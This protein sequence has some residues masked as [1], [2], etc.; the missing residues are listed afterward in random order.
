MG[1]ARE[2][3]VGRHA[4]MPSGRGTWARASGFTLI[5]V[6]IAIAV[7][8]ILTAIALPQYNEFVRRSRIVDATSQLNDF[9]TR[10]E[11]A[12]QDN[13]RYDDGAGNCAI[14]AQIPV[15][16]AARDNFAF[17]CTFNPG[18]LGGYSLLATGNAA[19]GML[20]FNYNLIVDPTTGALT[21]TTVNVPASWSGPPVPNTCWQTRKG[22]KC[23]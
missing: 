7:V 10:Q 9:R 19:M 17:T 11:Q 3:P 15:F 20:D 13:R 21:R 8:G 18:A 6:L 12:Y 2:I 23:S 22:G 14:Q 16:N 4:R 5:E 1:F